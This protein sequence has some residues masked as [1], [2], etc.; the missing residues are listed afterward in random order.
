MDRAYPGLEFVVA[1]TLA[2]WKKLEP[3]EMNFSQ[4][5]SQK[6]S[7]NCFVSA[8]SADNLCKQFGPRS[9]STKVGPDLDPNCLTFCIE[10]IQHRSKE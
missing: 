2:K 7:T 9:G 6:V 1:N 4:G 5:F 8:M 3:N 10:K